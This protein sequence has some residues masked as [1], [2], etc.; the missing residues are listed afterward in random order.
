MNEL[1]RRGLSCSSSSACSELVLQEGTRGAVA[2]V[3]PSVLWIRDQGRGSVWVHFDDIRLSVHLASLS[4]HVSSSG[5]PGRW[6]EWHPQHGRH[7]V[8]SILKKQRDSMCSCRCLC[9]TVARTT[10]GSKLSTCNCLF[11]CLVIKFCS[12]KE[13]KRTTQRETNS[14]SPQFF[15]CDL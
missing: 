1:L 14:F 6:C 3:K 13:K 2:P 15:I 10:R 11:F 7:L 4:Q 12:T 9:L 5:I 8:P